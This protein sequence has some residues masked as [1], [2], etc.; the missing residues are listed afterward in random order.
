[1]SYAPRYP[2]DLPIAVQMSL[3]SVPFPPCHRICLARSVVDLCPV[4]C[5]VVPS[6]QVRVDAKLEHHCADVPRG[7]AGGADKISRSARSFRIDSSTLLVLT[8][9]ALQFHCL[10]PYA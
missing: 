8:P 2:T 6:K 5:V 4:L 7:D 3:R 1:M 9:A 10:T